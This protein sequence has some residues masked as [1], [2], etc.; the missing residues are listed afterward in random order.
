MCLYFVPLCVLCVYV[1]ACLRYDAKPWGEAGYGENAFQSHSTKM[2]P[3]VGLG[4]TMANGQYWSHA[5]RSN[6]FSF[7]VR[8]DSV[9]SENMTTS[10]CAVSVPAQVQL[11]VP[12]EGLGLAEPEHPA[13]CTAQQEIWVGNSG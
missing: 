4:G 9:A 13:F 6:I 3:G 12:L 2:Q 11:T 10:L 5:S 8:L 7:P 1:C